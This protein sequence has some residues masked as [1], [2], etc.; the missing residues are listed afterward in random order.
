VVVADTAAATR[1]LLGRRGEGIGVPDYLVA[2]VC[3]ANG[4]PLLT[5]NVAH[6]SRVPGLV[7]ARI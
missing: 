1:R 6:F 2:G 3:I 7:L 4:Y 5:R